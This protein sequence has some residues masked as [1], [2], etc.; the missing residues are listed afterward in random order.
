MV[1][2]AHTHMQAKKLA[3]F[4]LNR[5]EIL[6]FLKI[7]NRSASLPAGMVRMV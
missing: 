2:T 5:F 3:N 7:R 4:R 1:I 6:V